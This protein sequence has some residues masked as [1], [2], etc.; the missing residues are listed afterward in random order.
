MNPE[1]NIYPI[2]TVPFTTDKVCPFLC[3]SVKSRL[4]MFVFQIWLAATVYRT[5]TVSYADDTTY[6]TRVQVVPLPTALALQHWDAA[7]QCCDFWDCHLSFYFSRVANAQK[8]VF[9]ISLSL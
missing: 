3:H 6:W 8:R 4:H 5:D 7:K 9:L 1:M 2:E